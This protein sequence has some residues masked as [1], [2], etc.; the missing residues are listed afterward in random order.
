MGWGE[1][2]DSG[3]D[4][5]KRGIDLAL[6]LAVL[7]FLLVIMAIVAVCIKLDTK[8]SVFFNDYRIG[9]D[10]KKFLCYKFRSMRI[11]ADRVL[12]QY[13]SENSEAKAEWEEFQKLKGY[14]PRVTGVGKFIRST[15]IDELPQLINVLLGDMSLVGPRPYLP[16]EQKMIGKY[17]DTIC[18]VRPGITGIW[19]VSGRNDVSFAGR[20]QMDAWYVENRSLGLDIACLCKT[21]KI[22][23]LGKGAY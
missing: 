22:V 5:I 4:L 18:R 8:G 20:L 21:V 13:L 11:D 1:T 6:C 9:K 10:G 7:P 16:R 23:L 15:S 12:E 2:K 14:D 17:L 19:Q 3:Q